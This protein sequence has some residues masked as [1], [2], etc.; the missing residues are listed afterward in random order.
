MPNMT[1]KIGWAK[2][3]TRHRAMKTA[4]EVLQPSFGS[5]GRVQKGTVV[6]G[7]IEGDIHDI[8]K[9]LVAAMLEGSGYKVVDLGIDVKT[10][11]FVEAVK[12]HR[13]DVVAMSGVITTTIKHMPEVVQS[14]REAGLREKVLVAMGGT[15]VTPEFARDS[16]ADIFAADAASAARAI[17]GAVEARAR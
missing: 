17:D 5:G 14:L 6:I 11:V 13:P 1:V 9:N 7:T 12:E 3:V 2:G 4:V 8:G 16:G 15:C 10:A